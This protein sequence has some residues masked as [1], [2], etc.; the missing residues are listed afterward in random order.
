MCT[1]CT[2]VHSDSVYSVY[3]LCTVRRGTSEGAT[4]GVQEPYSQPGAHLWRERKEG[5]EASN[6]VTGF[7]LS[8]Y[9]AVLT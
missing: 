6:L 5:Q 8:H 4:E 3:I 1:L 9:S 2:S 7:S